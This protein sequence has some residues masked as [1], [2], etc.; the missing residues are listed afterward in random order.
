MWY[1]VILPVRALSATIIKL[2]SFLVPTFVFQKRKERKRDICFSLSNIMY[3]NELFCKG[4]KN[5]TGKSSRKRKHKAL[6]ALSVPPM[7]Y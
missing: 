2:P 5:R 4:L 7:D 1:E 3:Y 6:K